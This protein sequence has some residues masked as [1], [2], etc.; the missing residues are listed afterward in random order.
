MPNWYAVACRHCD[1]QNRIAL[2]FTDGRT[3][4][5]GLNAQAQNG[6]RYE[7]ARAP[8]VI[9]TPTV[10]ALHHTREAKSPFIF[11]ETS[12]GVEGHCASDIAARSL[13]PSG[14]AANFSYARAGV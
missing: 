1:W 7:T 2:K 6:V 11:F 14:I 5:Q 8:T 10:G 4:T 3:P 13:A 9:S 12:A